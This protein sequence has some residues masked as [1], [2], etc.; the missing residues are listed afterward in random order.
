MMVPTRLIP[1]TGEM[2]SMENRGQQLTSDA[3]TQYFNVLPETN[4]VEYS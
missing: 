2:F 3:L 1:F 4:D